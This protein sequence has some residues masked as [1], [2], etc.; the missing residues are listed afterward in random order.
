MLPVTRLR[1]KAT[2]RAGLKN[3]AAF[4]LGCMAGC[5]LSSAFYIWWCGLPVACHGAR[6]A[7]A[8]SLQPFFRVA[9]VGPPWTVSNELQQSS[10]KRL[11][12]AVVASRDGVHEAVSMAKETWAS[13]IETSVEY[14][15]FV[16]GKGPALPNVHWLRGMRDEEGDIRQLFHVLKHLYSSFADRYHWFLLA[17]ANTYIA[18]QSIHEMLADMNLL[19]SVYLGSWASE[20]PDVMATLHLLPNEYFCEWGPG[21]IIN[22]AALAAVMSH[23][24][25]CKH[26]SGLFGSHSRHRNRNLTLGVGGDVELGRCFSRRVG[27]QCT[28]SQEVRKLA[29]TV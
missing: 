2:D 8:V 24:D 25:S 1:K 16:A 20:D 9:E 13:R 10:K 29:H 28:S 14:R 15:I 5:L 6:F 22:H 27:I 11:L 19:K 18:V 4:L 12:I 21:I 7:A 3:R 23:L 26:L 17:P